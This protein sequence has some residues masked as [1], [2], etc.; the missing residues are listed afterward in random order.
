MKSLRIAAAALLAL[1]LPSAAEPLP[2]LFFTPAQ[3]AQ[4]E[5][6]RTAGHLDALPA[7]RLDG[8]VVRSTGA[9]TVWVNG[10]PQ[11]RLAADLPA[12]LRVGERFDHVSGQRADVLAAGVLRVGGGRAQ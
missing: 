5:R 10:Q 2:R 1:S 6:Q 9:S 3:R 8:R 4:F 11:I 12:D 7:I